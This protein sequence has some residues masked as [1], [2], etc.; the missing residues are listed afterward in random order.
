MRRG[1]QSIIVV[2]VMLLWCVDC[3]AQ[4]YGG[5]YG[6]GNWGGWGGYY[7]G[8]GSTPYSSAVRAQA[9]LTQARGVAA[10]SYARA[11]GAAEQARSQY[12]ENQA[13]FV[14][15]RRQQ[16]AAME[17][18]KVKREAEAKARAA[19]RPAPRPHTELYPRLSVDQ[20]DPLTGEIHWPACYLAPEFAADRELIEQALKEQAEHGP[21]DRTAKILY[22]AAYRM[23]ATRSPD[24]LKLSSQDY[25]AAHRFLKSLAYEGEHAREALK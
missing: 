8:E 14:E 2:V 13:R 6:Y 24:L 25:A 11:A 10:E 18:D 23:G 9:E 15:L 21:E 19:R 4:W 12:L 17:A 16:K 7:S 1:V 22:D 20:L 3:R 5:W